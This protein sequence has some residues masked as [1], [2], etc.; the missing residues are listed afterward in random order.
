MRAVAKAARRQQ[1]TPPPTYQE[2]EVTLRLY[3]RVY[4]PSRPVV[5]T[6]STPRCSASATAR[7]A[8]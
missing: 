6:G 4:K 5:G 7:T 1:A 2:H 8:P 3:H